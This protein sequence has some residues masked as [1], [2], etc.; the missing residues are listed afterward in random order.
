MEII[1]KKVAD[2]SLRDLYT[3]P[4]SYKMKRELLKIKEER[5]DVNAMIRD[6]LVLLLKE[7]SNQNDEAT[8]GT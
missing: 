2:E 3:V 8:G 4:V 7:A 5:I 6:F 1:R